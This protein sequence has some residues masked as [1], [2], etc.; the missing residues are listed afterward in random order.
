MAFIKHTKGTSYPSF[1]AS[2]IGLRTKTRQIEESMGSEGIVK[3]GAIYPADDAT[4]EGLVFEAVDVSDGAMPGSVMTAGEVYEDQLPA[5]PS[6]A[7]KTAMN[8]LG[9]VFIPTKP[10]TERT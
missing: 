10:K 8:K 9:M 7:A 3:P 1:L 5:K 4:A 6:E 2:E